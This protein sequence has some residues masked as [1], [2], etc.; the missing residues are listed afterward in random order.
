MEG[1]E[2]AKAMAIAGRIDLFIFYC[3]CFLI[4]SAE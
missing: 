1:M 2:K 4:M 3:G